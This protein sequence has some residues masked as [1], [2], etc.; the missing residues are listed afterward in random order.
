MILNKTAH[1][2]WLAFIP[3]PKEDKNLGALCEDASAGD[4]IIGA[5]T[6]ALEH[7]YRQEQA[8]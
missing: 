7:F 1:G 5:L 8:A 6:M 3:Y 4:A 2:T